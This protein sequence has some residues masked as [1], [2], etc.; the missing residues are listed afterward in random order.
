MCKC[1][2]YNK[3]H[4]GIP[5]DAVYVGRPTVW[6]NPFSKGSKQQNIEDFREYA[7]ERLQR[8][9]NWLNPLRDKDLVCWCAPAGCHGD[10]LVELANQESEFDWDEWADANCPEY[11]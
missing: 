1:R 2:V 3:R 7:V 6:G 8:E 9:P 5:K 11:Y 4:N 10:V